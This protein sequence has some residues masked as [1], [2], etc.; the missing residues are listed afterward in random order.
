MQEFPPLEYTLIRF[1]S[2]ICTVEKN[3]WP[4]CITEVNENGR[5]SLQMWFWKEAWAFRWKASYFY[6]GSFQLNKKPLTI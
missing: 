3:I 4:V 6:L 1:G 2:Q 5:E